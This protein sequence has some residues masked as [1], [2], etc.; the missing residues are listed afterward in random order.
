MPITM[1]P[2]RRAVLE[3]AVSTFVTMQGEDAAAQLKATVDTVHGILEATAEWEQKE[4]VQLLDLL[5]GRIPG[6]LWAG[7]ARPFA[8]LPLADRV[9]LLQKWSQSNLGPLRKAFQSLKKLS[10]F[11]HYGGKGPGTP[12]EWK[13]I[14]Y[15][16]PLRQPAGPPARIQLYTPRAEEVIDCD[17]VVVGSGAGGGITAGILAEAGYSVVVLEKGPY[18]EGADFDQQEVESIRRTYEKQGAMA[19]RDGGVGI[20]AGSCLGGGTT[21]NW[22][23]CF[24]TPDYVRGEW[25]K[26]AG[27]DFAL[28]SDY[29]AHMSDVM[30]SI[31]VN[32]DHSTLNAQNQVLWK[33]IEKLG[34]SPG[35]IARNVDGCGGEV[36]RDCGYC[37]LGCRGGTKQ[38]T[39]RTWLRRAADRG[40]RILAHTHAER[41][42]Q[43]GGK[44]SGLEATYQVPGQ[45]PVRF[46]V[47]AKRVVVAAGSLHSPAL[48][49]RSGITHPGIGRNL[50]FHPTVVVAGFYKDEMQ[51]W[52]G[53]MMTALDRGGMRLDG[54]YGH[55]IETPPV[56]A[57]L[58]ALALPWES[59]GRHREDVARM[60]HMG[61]FVVLTRDKFGGR[62]T[63]DKQGQP[64]VDYQLNAYDRAH[65]LHG[66]RTAFEIHRAA[67][68]RDVVFPH[69]RYNRYNIATSKMSAEK[70]LDGMAGWG[71]GANRFGLFTAHQMG[72]CS[73]GADA[74][75]HPFN[76]QG[77]C[78][79]LPGLFIADGSA[80]PTCAGV[81][82]MVTI[83][84]LA[85]WVA[86]GMA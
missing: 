58:A 23:A 40:A 77:E 6:L 52:F 36:H 64:L 46:S 78:H 76:P 42:L 7:K 35:L 3:A 16:G 4:F 71:W 65:M 70:Y 12:A 32:R 72:T 38:S 37:G 27:L 56:H 39:L 24:E 80:L 74:R 60:A 81:N 13:V 84:A 53:P 67:G 83:M 14:G 18:V 48:L 47:R 28:S 66:I 49:L 73:M 62:V 19:S 75:R 5:S 61:S 26:D 41:I 21:I 8:E 86:K 69:F 2:A 20:F 22:T 82:P 50:F 85:G 33:G 63:L 54:N 31:H 9:K 10:L 17:V 55:W 79:A 34:R 45:A 68:A 51:P 30:A 15:P 1:S 57:G 25:A 44:A 59:P 43:A 29:E 11:V